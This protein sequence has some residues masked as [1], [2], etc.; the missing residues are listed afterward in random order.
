MYICG[1]TPDFN[2]D[3]ASANKFPPTKITI[4]EQNT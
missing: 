1:G 4:P 2:R 3:H